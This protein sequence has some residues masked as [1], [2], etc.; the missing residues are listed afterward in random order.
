M[1]LLSFWL[2]NWDVPVSFDA[3]HFQKSQ[4]ALLD[5]GVLY[6]IYLMRV[7]KPI[8]LSTQNRSRI[9]TLY[10]KAMHQLKYDHFWFSRMLGRVKEYRELDLLGT[11]STHNMERVW[12]S[13]RES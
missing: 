7:F 1:I 2:L 6:F 3:L 8:L 13:E 5:Q 9:P 10:I 11:M 12:R 4:P